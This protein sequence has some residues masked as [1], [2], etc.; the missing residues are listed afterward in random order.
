MLK[1]AGSIA[2]SSF[3]PQGARAQNRSKVLVIGAGL[4]GLN[5]ALILE[6]LGVDV[7][8]IEG[9]RRVGG[10]VFSLYDV[11]GAPDAGG[12]SFG[13]GYGHVL[14]AANKYGVPVRNLMDR[15][16]Y[17][18]ARELV[19]NGKIVP[20]QDWPNHTRN[21]FPQEQKETLPWSFFPAFLSANNPLTSPGDWY[22]QENA[23]LDISAHDWMIAQG[24]IEAVIEACNINWASGHTA[25]DVSILQMMFDD[26]VTDKARAETYRPGFFVAKGGNQRV[27]DAMAAALKSE[28]H[29]ERQVIGLRTN[30]DGAEVQCSDGSVYKADRVICSVPFAVLRLLKVDPLFTGVQAKAVRQLGYQL[31]T[32][33]H[34]VPRSPF[35]ESDGYASGLFTDGPAGIINPQFGADDPHELTSFTV[36]LFGPNAERVDQID[37]D[38][39]KA[40]IVAEIERIRPAAKGQL[41]IAGYKSWY[42]DPFSSGDWS[43]FKPG[44]VTAFVKKMAQPHGR[45]H[46]C[47]EHTG[48]EARGMEGA[49]ESGER[50]AFEIYELI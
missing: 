2:A 15:I 46:F 23:A 31:V 17:M 8:L 16:Q 28:V 13:G 11:P 50:A 24:Q 49:M 44:Q 1:G 10:R 48:L 43:V 40:M 3:L 19:L 45:I 37:E 7:Q 22:E 35:W 42:R 47:G 12:A 33:V 41:E 14:D 4:S 36:W 39:A 26:A 25:H 34:L 6:E 30:S 5:A 29:L 9:R 20:G 38:S 32:Q 27:P 21:P 18:M